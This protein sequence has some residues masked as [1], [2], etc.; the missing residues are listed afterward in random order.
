MWLQ[1]NNNIFVF[2]D[3]TFELR[4]AARLLRSVQPAL[5]AGE[6]KRFVILPVLIVLHI[7]YSNSVVK[8]NHQKKLKAEMK[9]LNITAF[10]CRLFMASTL[11][12]EYR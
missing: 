6:L 5:F 2:S 10:D 3:I 7:T 12:S 4:G 1:P 8:V 11:I 9:E